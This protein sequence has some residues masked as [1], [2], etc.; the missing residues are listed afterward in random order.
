VPIHA[1][2]R[3]HTIDFD[4]SIQFEDEHA[5]PDPP[6]RITHDEEIAL[7]DGSVLMSFQ[8]TARMTNIEV[9]FRM[10]PQFTIDYLGEP[11]PLDHA[12]TAMLHYVRFIID[13]VAHGPEPADLP[14]AEPGTAT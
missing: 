14:P 10:K 11:V 2:V 3:V 1:K 8:S 5:I 7:E 9:P 6:C 13:T 4:A 12:L